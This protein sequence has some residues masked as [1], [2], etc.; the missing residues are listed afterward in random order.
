MT[1]Y[2]VYSK[3]TEYFVD[4][5]EAPSAE[6]ARAIIDSRDIDSLSM[7]Y[8]DFEIYDVESE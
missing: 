1:K 2:F 3:H 7:D 6:E 4:E 8:A 5:V